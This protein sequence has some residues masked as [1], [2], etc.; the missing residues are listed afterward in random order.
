MS[1][2]THNLNR[3]RQVTLVDY[4]NC[5]HQQLV[6]LHDQA[7]TLNEDHQPTVRTADVREFYD[8]GVSV[9]AA[10]DDLY[11]RGF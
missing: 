9:D 2:R 3:N 5:V 11:H 7:G 6:F 4:A 10:A 8:H 1:Y